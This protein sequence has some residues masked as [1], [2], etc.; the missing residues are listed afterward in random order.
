ML[1]KIFKKYFN[2]VPNK[3]KIIFPDFSLF[4]YISMAIPN[5]EMCYF[6]TPRAFNEVIRRFF[7]SPLISRHSFR[8]VRSFK[9][10]G[11]KSREFTI[12]R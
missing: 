4:D 3:V 2:K 11:K 7:C 8:C 12:E 6:K 1:V 9:S 10:Y 5:Q